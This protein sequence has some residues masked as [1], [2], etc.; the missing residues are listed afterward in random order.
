LTSAL[1]TWGEINFSLNLFFSIIISKSMSTFFPLARLYAAFS[2][3]Y[4]LAYYILTLRSSLF[5]YIFFIS[6][7]LMEFDAIYLPLVI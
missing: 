4:F 1:E 2:C 3:F 5:C 6:F 7:M